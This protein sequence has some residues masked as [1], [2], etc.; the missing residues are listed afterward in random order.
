MRWRTSPRHARMSTAVLA[1]ALAF[2]CAISGG[3]DSWAKSPTPK[4]T[5]IKQLERKIEAASD[6]V[7]AAGRKVQSA[8][9]SYKRYQLTANRAWK[10]YKRAVAQSDSAHATAV[11]VRAQYWRAV[12]HSRSSAARLAQ[13]KGK[14]QTT[15]TRYEQTV[16]N[17]YMGGGSM[18]QLA[19]VLDTIDP[20]DLALRV[21]GL[22]VLGQA[23]KAR[24][25]SLN[26]ARE[27]RAA[28]LAAARTNERAVEA[29]S[30]RLVAADQRA[31][32]AKAAAHSALKQS[33]R[34][35]ANASAA[36]R[37]ARTTYANAMSQLN[38]LKA[39]QRGVDTKSQTHSSGVRPGS[40]AWPVRGHTR[41]SSYA[42]GRVHPVF[43]RAACHAGI[44]IPAGSGTPI[45]AAAAGVVISAS[46]VRGYGNMTLI[47]HGGGMA[48]LYGHQSKILVRSGQHVK[49]NQ[50]IGKVGST[51][52]STGPHLH[53]EVRLA[54][55]PYNPLGWFGGSR[56][57]VS[58]YHK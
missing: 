32:A 47:A 7:D 20:A 6:G 30:V 3:A 56:S 1:F 25:D 34:A 22:D 52:W 14:L 31:A 15:Q 26:T 55:Q 28:R 45:H 39:A 41:I 2:A 8:R 10:T 27:A 11:S 57:A 40:L 13:T 42:G 51:G 38:R 35:T 18:V 16:R 9:N 49:K 5:R 29:L 43:G 46:A 21:Q 4:P 19:V 17:V 23:H 54:G 12:G 53:F 37:A 24:I 44:D 58:C 33:K 36:L 48:T 50:I